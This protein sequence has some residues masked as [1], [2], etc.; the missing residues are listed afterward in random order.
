[1]AVAEPRGRGLY[2][3][4]PRAEAVPEHL[5]R[6]RVIVPGQRLPLLRRRATAQFGEDVTE[7]LEVIPRPW[8]VIQHVREK[9]ACRDC[10]TISQAP[11]PFM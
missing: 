2:P 10:E 4:A 7:T 8:K 6:E 3:Q 11:A 5:P 1:M 9:F